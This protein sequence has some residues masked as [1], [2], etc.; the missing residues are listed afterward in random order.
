MYCLLQGYIVFCGGVLSSAL[1]IS[2][3]S[4]SG[5]PDADGRIYD[6]YVS[7]VPA[8]PQFYF[9]FG[10]SYTTFSY[11]G[12]SVTTTGAKDTPVRVRFTVANTGSVEGEEVAQVYV[13]DPPSWQFGQILVRPWKRLA[14]F[15]RV[16]LA[17]GAKQTVGVGE[18]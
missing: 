9:G 3:Y 17:P 13:V 10:L 7:N 6:P 11:S 8:S 4:Y 12:V 14:A 15:T 5:P 18:K 2:S 16:K 1:P